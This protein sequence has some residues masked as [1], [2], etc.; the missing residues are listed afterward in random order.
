MD[1]SLG[2][3]RQDHFK[4]A[5]PTLN[6]SQPNLKGNGYTVEIAKDW[7]MLK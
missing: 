1:P 3:S 4:G 7:L 5:R 6:L 2:V